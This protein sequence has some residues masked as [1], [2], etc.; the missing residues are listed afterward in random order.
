MILR[1]KRDLRGGLAP[2]DEHAAPAHDVEQPFLPED[3]D[4]GP[5]RHPAHAVALAE[6]GF[7]WGWRAGAERA[8][9]AFDDIPRPVDVLM[10]LSA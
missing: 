9:P 10:L 8:N 7:G 3:R 1:T 2:G 6:L 5:G 4:R